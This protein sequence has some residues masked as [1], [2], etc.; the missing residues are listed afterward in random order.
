MCVCV[1]GLHC[2]Q[3]TL[4]ASIVIRS[5][6]RKQDVIRITVPPPPPNHPFMM[7]ATLSLLHAVTSLQRARSN[8]LYV[9]IQTLNM[10]I[11]SL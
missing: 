7:P 3:F 8:V 6:A 10:E 5:L 2:G 1:S 11:V 9:I 4:A